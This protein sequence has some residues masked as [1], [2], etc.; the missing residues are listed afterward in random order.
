MHGSFIKAV[1]LA[2]KDQDDAEVRTLKEG[3]ELWTS[4]E[5]E[6]ESHYSQI[7]ENVSQMQKDAISDLDM[8]E[9]QISELIQ[10]GGGRG[11]DT[12][13]A[14]QVDSS[15]LAKMQNMYQ[16]AISDLKQTQKE[17]QVCLSARSF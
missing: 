14:S 9:K 13:G 7:V 16:K 6:N 2:V 8:L 1:N 4:M 15:E 17:L 11:E 12:M 5:I 10:Q 3:L